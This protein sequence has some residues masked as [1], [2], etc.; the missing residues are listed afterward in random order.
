MSRVFPAMERAL[1]RRV[2]I[3]VLPSETVGALSV[4]RF[5]R[6]IAIAARPQQ[7]NIAP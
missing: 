2:V 4:E 3:K 6:E 5:T 1:G 7:A